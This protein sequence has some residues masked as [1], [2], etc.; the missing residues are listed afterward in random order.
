M[1][2]YALVEFFEEN[3]VQAVVHKSWI[4]SGDGVSCFSLVILIG[5]PMQNAH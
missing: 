1:L 5:L 3:S 2:D 4:V